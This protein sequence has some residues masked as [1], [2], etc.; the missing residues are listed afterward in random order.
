MAQYWVEWLLEFDKLC[1]KKKERCQ[2]IRRDFAPQEDDAGLDI[3]FLVWDAILSEAKNRSQK[4]L[5]TIISSILNLFKMRFSISVK[6]RRRHLIY[7]AI[8]LLCEPL[9]LKIDPLQFQSSLKSILQNLD[10]IYLQVKKG[11]VSSSVVE[12]ARTLIEQKKKP[13]TQKEIDAKHKLDILSTMGFDPS[14]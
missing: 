7:M 13:K 14:E 8:N 2:C 3:I 1:R 11:E 5:Y 10:V 4:A 9:D 6:K 12:E